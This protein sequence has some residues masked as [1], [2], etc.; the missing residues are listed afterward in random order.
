MS[1]LTVDGCFAVILETY[2][3]VMV[4]LMSTL[5]VD[6]W[7]KEIVLQLSGKGIVGLTEI[8]IDRLL[9]DWKAGVFNPMQTPWNP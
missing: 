7:S 1:T 5:T 6:D 2:V 9:E 3:T 8:E 4:E